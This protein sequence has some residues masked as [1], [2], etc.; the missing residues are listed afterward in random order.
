MFIPAECLSAIHKWVRWLKSSARNWLF[1]KNGKWVIL[2][3]LC[4]WNPAKGKVTGNKH[5]WIPGMCAETHLGPPA[6]LQVIMKRR[7]HFIPVFKIVKFYV[8]YE[9]ISLILLFLFNEDQCRL[10]PDSGTYVF[11]FFLILSMWCNAHTAGLQN[12]V[13]SPSS[14]EIS[15]KPQG[16]RVHWVYR[17]RITYY[18]ALRIIEDF[19]GGSSFLFTQILKSLGN[20]S[21]SKRNMLNWRHLVLCFS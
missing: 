3:P 7:Q 6:G 18:N 20:Y 15:A 12:R 14:C 2:Q 8:S 17:G 4:N 16:K 21:P 5:V 1:I 9:N 13:I 10:C 19:Y 11:L